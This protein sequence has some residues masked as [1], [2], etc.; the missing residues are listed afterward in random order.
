MKVEVKEEVKVVRRWQITGSRV[1]TIWGKGGSLYRQVQSY[2]FT[3]KH[4]NLDLEVLGYYYVIVIII[5]L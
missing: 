5:Y 1:E 2:H 4:P 3:L